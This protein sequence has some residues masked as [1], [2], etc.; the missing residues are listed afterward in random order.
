MT[1]N[2]RLNSL[3]E[4]RTKINELKNELVQQSYDIFT[5]LQKEIFTKYPE[6]ESFGWSQY[7]PYFNDGDTCVFSANTNY[8]KINYV[9][10]CN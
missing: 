3:S 7:T 4:T 2:E 8:I 10:N 6:L 9:T 5:D 1:I